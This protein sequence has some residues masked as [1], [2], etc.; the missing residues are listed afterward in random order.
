MFTRVCERCPKETRDFS[1]SC[2]RWGGESMQI[3]LLSAIFLRLIFCCIAYFHKCYVCALMRMFVCLYICL[4]WSI[5]SVCVDNVHT[6]NQLIRLFLYLW[7]ATRYT[8]LHKS[9]AIY[10]LI[11]L[12]F[13]S[14][15]VLVTACDKA[16]SVDKYQNKKKKN[17]KR[18]GTWSSSYNT[19]IHLELY[20]EVFAWSLYVQN[21]S[22]AKVQDYAVGTGHSVCWRHWLRSPLTQCQRYMRMP[23]ASLTVC[24]YVRMHLCVS[25]Y[26]SCEWMVQLMVI[27]LIVKIERVASETAWMNDLQ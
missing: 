25:S 16:T 8:A 13:L 3:I 24:M 21:T 19:F 14:S 18:N 17:K 9:R 10:C 27:N 26:I 22:K 1:A 11:S 23:A 2:G 6:L 5:I 4:C 7:P 12:W 15:K 20:M